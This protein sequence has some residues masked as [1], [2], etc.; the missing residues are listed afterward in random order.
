MS[1]RH[2]VSI[3]DLSEPD[4]HQLL[5][6][7]EWFMPQVEAGGF[8]MDTLRGTSCILLFYEA[9]TRTRASFEVAGKMLG[10]D[11]INVG[12]KGSSTEKG[13]TVKD[14]ALTLNAMDHNCV[15]MRHETADAINIFAQYFERGLVNAGSGL[16]Q[17][18]TQ[19]LLDALTL[20]RAGLL[21]KGRRVAIVG[22]LRHSRVMR[23]NLQLWASL[24][25]DTVLVAP[26]QLMPDG[27]EGLHPEHWA[28]DTTGYG[29]VTWDTDID[30]VLPDVD[31]VMMLRMQ[32]ERMDGGY[33]TNSDEY[34]KLYGLFGHRMKKLP[35]HAI[36]MHPGP[37][38]RGV[39]ISEEA[40]LDP[41]CRITEQVTWGV[42]SRCA[43]LCW[44][45]GRL[46]VGFAVTA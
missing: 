6:L 11:T 19:A 29:S 13:E 25:M 27:W 23:S 39:E 45:C 16:G 30:R 3:R 36:I 4:L 12:S 26:P 28:D 42:A 37:V 17:H 9:S 2:L 35:P 14:T 20:R 18:P 38:N 33:L 5:D 44:S 40:F 41:R 32:R 22:D 24:G 10:S 7:S 43:L 8:K 15:V 34:S 31:A 1:Y 21:E 46:P